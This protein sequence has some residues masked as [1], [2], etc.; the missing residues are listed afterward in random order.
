M[1]LKSE[2]V[3][4]ELECC[5]PACANDCVGRECPYNNGIYCVAI[6]AKRAISIIREKD[7]EIAMMAECIG[8]QDKE[9]AQKDAK[10]ER[11][12]GGKL[13]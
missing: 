13:T 11:L 10:I 9:L 2:D 4:R 12:K 6:I 1:E 3:I 7:A 5:I 8:R